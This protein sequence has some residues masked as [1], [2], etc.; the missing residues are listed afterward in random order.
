MLYPAIIE[1]FFIFDDLIY[2]FVQT[3]Q[4]KFSQLEYTKCPGEDVQDVFYCYRCEQ[5]PFFSKIII[6]ELSKHQ[7]KSKLQKSYI[8]FYL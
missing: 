4:N 5:L 6:R 8:Y 3:V 7:L 1:D 2:Q